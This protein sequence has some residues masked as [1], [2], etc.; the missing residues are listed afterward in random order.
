MKDL[1]SWYIWVM[2]VPDLFKSTSCRKSSYFSVF[3]CWKRYF[4][5]AFVFNFPLCCNYVFSQFFLWRRKYCFSNTCSF[6]TEFISIFLAF[7]HNI[8]SWLKK[9]RILFWKLVIKLLQNYPK[10]YFRIDLQLKVF[11]FSFNLTSYSLA[12]TQADPS[13][14]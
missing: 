12:L 2:H 3:M 7:L 5:S 8:K 4:S 1:Q 6:Y 11:A 10:P 13:V 14:H 9:K